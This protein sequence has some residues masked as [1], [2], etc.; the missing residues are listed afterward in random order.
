MTK[1]PTVVFA[2][3]SVVIKVFFYVFILQYCNNKEHVQDQE[4]VTYRLS[5]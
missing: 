2:F 1:Q 3:V 5:G 4:G